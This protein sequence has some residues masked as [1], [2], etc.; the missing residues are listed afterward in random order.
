MNEIENKKA[1][2]LILV[3]DDQPN[4]LKLIASVLSHEYSL[5]IANSGI[6]ALKMLENGVP[7]L[8]LLDIMM[9]EMDGFEVCKKIKENENT[10]NIPVIFLTA[11][12]DIDDIVKGFDYGAVDYITKPFNLVE[13]KVRIKNHLN[14]YHAKQEIE[15]INK[16]KDKFFSIIAHDLSGPFSSIVSFSELLSERIKENKLERIGDYADR[17][18]KASQKSINLLTNLMTWA[19]SKTGRM[20]FKPA[21]L[22]LSELINENILLFSE[23]ALQK[24]ISLKYSIPDGIQVFADKDM[25]SA[26]LRNLISNALK[27]TFPNGEINV[28]TETKT[29]EVIIYIKDNGMGMSDKLMEDLFKID[30]KTGRI[31]SAGELSTGLGLIICKEFIEKHKGEIWVESEEGKGSIFYVKIPN[32]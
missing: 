29:E 16:E 23:L 13:M 27:F 20:E 21:M 14:L 12:S 24:S 31:G 26:I 7:D 15:Q 10:K 8:I 18:F 6:N 22:N 9:P 4:N 2:D 17:I 28:A 30:K 19:R 11:K 1:K 32:Q 5:S 3:V 25:L